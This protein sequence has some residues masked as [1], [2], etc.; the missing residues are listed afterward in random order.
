MPT[1]AST[2]WIDDLDRAL[3]ELAVDHDAAPGE[4]PIVIQQVVTFDEPDREPAAWYV[5]VE[6][7]AVS[8]RAGRAASPDITFTQP[9]E[10]AEAVHRGEIS[11]REAFMLGRI[12]I[13]GDVRL[14]VRSQALFT[15][16]AEALSG[17]REAG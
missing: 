4:L 10:V 15:A 9:L 12:R 13:G 2:A 14:L 16:L 17:M 3:T 11:A 8:A 7:E 5:T 6:P 1:F